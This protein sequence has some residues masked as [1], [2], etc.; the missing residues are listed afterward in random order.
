[1]SG[2][3]VVIEYSS[4]FAVHD[5]RTGEEHPMGDG[6]DAIFSEDCE[7]LSPGTTGFTDAWQESLNANEDETLEAYFPD[8]FLVE[9]SDE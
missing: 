4:F 5:T 1:M 6:V 8:Q 7:P 9:N 2:R 3:F